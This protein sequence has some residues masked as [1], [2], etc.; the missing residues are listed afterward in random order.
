[1]AHQTRRSQGGISTPLTLKAPVAKP[2]GLEDGRYSANTKL[3]S[4]RL[5]RHRSGA[6]RAAPPGAERPVKARLVAPS[7]DQ[8]ATVGR[9]ATRQIFDPVA[10]HLG[11]E[12]RPGPA[13]STASG[14]CRR[15][16]GSLAQPQ[17][18]VCRPYVWPNFRTAG[19]LSDAESPACPARADCYDSFVAALERALLR[20]FWWRCSV[21]LGAPLPRWASVPR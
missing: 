4:N 14:G 15:S 12:E 11:G 6:N 3:G 2:A 7:S 10:L 13:T 16:A 20:A 1:M 19:G 9:L 5:F 18:A 21:R 8:T 17:R